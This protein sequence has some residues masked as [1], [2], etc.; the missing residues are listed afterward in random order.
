[1]AS[2]S[3]ESPVPKYEYETLPSLKCIRLLEITYHSAG[4]GEFEGKL[5]TT[6]LEQNDHLPYTAL[7][8]TWKLPETAAD[9]VERPAAPAV[10]VD[11]RRLAIGNILFD[12]LEQAMDDP[13]KPELPGM[14]WIDAVCI[15]Q[16]DLTER[17]TQVAFMRDI[18]HLAGGVVVWLGRHDVHSRLAIPLIASFAEVD[19]EEVVKVN[20]L[21]CQP[22]T[23]PEFYEHN[24]MKPLS[25]ADWNHIRSFHSRSWFHRLWTMQEVLV[26]ENP[27]LLCGE[28]DLDW[29]AM[30]LFILVVILRG[31][32]NTL[33]VNQF[34]ETWRIESGVGLVLTMGS[35]YHEKFTISPHVDRSSQLLFELFEYKDL[36]SFI[37]AKLAWILQMGRCRKTTDQRD[38]IFGPQGLV[39]QYYKPGDWDLLKPDYAMTVED[40]FT[41]AT[42]YILQ[43]LKNLSILSCVEDKSYRAHPDLPSWV[44]DFSKLLRPVQ[45]SIT[46]SYNASHGIEG[47]L[48]PIQI[49][50]LSVDVYLFDSTLHLPRQ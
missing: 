1:M 44:P 36:D 9:P 8:Y 27:M 21:H 19:I 45:L 30:T 40:V 34:L 47:N 17:S 29:N 24:N 23:D 12:F 6:D 2:S 50:E 18:Y 32:G 41:Q 14:L 31:W 15:N 39:S 3:A 37:C 13:D 48:P 7:S 42:R 20:L 4:S 38:R 22:L 11:G 25:L 49:L 43:K 5:H 33:Q 26:T 10:V 46:R 35:I 16:E 28:T